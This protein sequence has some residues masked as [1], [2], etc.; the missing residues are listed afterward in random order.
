MVTL[1]APVLIRTSG[2]APAVRLMTEAILAPSELDVMASLLQH[3]ADVFNH[4]GGDIRAV[5]VALEGIGGWLRLHHGE[6]AAEL[7][8]YWLDEQKY[9][10]TLD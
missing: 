5:A 1:A 6:P 2:K 4:E 9:R 8:A 7:I 10:V 3:L